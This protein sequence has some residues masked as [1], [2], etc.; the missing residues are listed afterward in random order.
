MRLS[1]ESPFKFY[2]IIRSE[3]EENGYYKWLQLDEANR[4]VQSLYKHDCLD[5]TQMGNYHI[6]EEEY[7]QSVYIRNDIDEY[8]EEYIPIIVS[9]S[10]EENV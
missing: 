4:I 8:S 5:L 3:R 9:L 7:T 10:T 1:T 2:K 6:F